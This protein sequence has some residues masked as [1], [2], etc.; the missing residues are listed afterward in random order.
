M[1]LFGHGQ[2]ARVLGEELAADVVEDEEEQLGGELEEG[3]SWD[4]SINGCW[5]R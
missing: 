4:W 5:W 3:H 2:A 1:P